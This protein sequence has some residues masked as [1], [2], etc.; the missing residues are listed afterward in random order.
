VRYN[1]SWGWYWDRGYVYGAGGLLAVQAGGVYWAH[2]DPVTK[3]QR[4]TDAA[5]NVTSGIELDPWGGETN[6]SFNSAFQP[7]KYTSYERDG[8][9]SD[10]AMFRRYNRWWGRFDQPDPWDGSY[11]LADPQSFNRYAYTQSDPVNFTDPTGLTMENPG[12]I[13]PYQNGWNQTT[14]PTLSFLNGAMRDFIRDYNWYAREAKGGVE[15]FGF[16]SYLSFGQDRRQNPRPAPLP[17]PT[18]KPTPDRSQQKQFDE[19]AKRAWSTYRRRYVT[20]TGKAALGGVGIGL[21]V[22]GLGRIGTTIGGLS[23]GL[24][25]VGRALSQ[26]SMVNKNTFTAV[27]GWLGGSM[28]WDAVHEGAAIERQ[29]SSDLKDCEKQSPNANHSL[30]FLNF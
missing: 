26:T 24:Q 4:L 8:N 16:F 7:R 18:P 30:T 5:G 29:L 22:V 6:R 10:E 19:C 2:Q 14:N 1:P 21:G 20:S 12:F 27:S 23:S 17:T 9:S 3:G 11:D 13:P 25:A 15:I 28:G